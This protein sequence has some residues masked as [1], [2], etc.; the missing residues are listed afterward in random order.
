MHVLPPSLHWYSCSFQWWLILSVIHVSL[1]L[2][3][4]IRL[5]I[6][7]FLSTV[8]QENKYRHKYISEKIPGVA[9]LKD[10]TDKEKT[11]ITVQGER[12]LQLFSHFLIS[13]LFRDTLIPRLTQ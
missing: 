1:L 10:K 2:N 9:A 11:L 3:Q 8:G 7:P 4:E 6:Y 12:L 5:F 13:G